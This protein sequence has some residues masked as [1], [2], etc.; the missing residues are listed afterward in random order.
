M[1]RGEQPGRM[2]KV[3]GSLD[4]S[5]MINSRI[6]DQCGRAGLDEAHRS[7]IFRH[8]RDKELSPVQRFRTDVR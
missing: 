3:S 7:D 4:G 8:S 2:A 5:G 1:R 6:H